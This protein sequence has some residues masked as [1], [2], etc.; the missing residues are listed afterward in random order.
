MLATAQGLGGFTWA[1]PGARL[2]ARAAAHLDRTRQRWRASSRA[3]RAL[4][5]VLMRLARVHALVRHGRSH[6]EVNRADGADACSAVCLL[7][8]LHAAPPLG[9][10]RRTRPCP[11]CCCRLWQRGYSTEC[12]WLFRFEWGRYGAGGRRRRLQCRLP[13]PC[14]PCRAAPRF[15]PPHPSLP[16]VLQVV[17]ARVLDGVLVALSL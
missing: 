14:P 17:A 10:P 5:G 12:W 7:R 2:V 11:R 9:S 6:L 3:K 16:A 13:P 4:H 8:V 15:T 1:G